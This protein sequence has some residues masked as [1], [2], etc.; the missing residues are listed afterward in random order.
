MKNKKTLYISVILAICLFPAVFMFAENASVDTNSEALVRQLQSQIKELQAQIAELKAQ[1]ETAKTEIN[2]LTK[3]LRRGEA[4][5]DVKKLQE[6]LK[7]D[8]EV[9]PESL[10]T[11]YFGPLTEKAVKKFQEK[12]ADVSIK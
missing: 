7:K 6:F 4:G 5:E 2:Y 10:V 1:L 3:M 11:G 8:P 12:H 9:Y